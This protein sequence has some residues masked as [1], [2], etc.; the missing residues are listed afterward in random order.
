MME[1]ELIADYQCVTG[2]GPL[3]QP[4]EQCVYWVD[5]PL[6]RMFRYDPATGKHEQFYE[7]GVIGGYTLQAD[8]SFLLF[9][10]KGAIKIL[11]NGKLM[12]VLDGIPGEEASRFNDVIADPRGG[13][14]CGTMPSPDSL[15]HLYYLSPEGQITKL[16]DGIAISNGFGF[17]PD[18]KQ[19]YYTLSHPKRI[20]LFDYNQTTGA[21]ANQRVFVDTTGE[22]GV[23]DGMAVD[24][25]GDVWS[26]RWD[27]WR[28]TRYNAMGKELQR[29]QFPVK[30][31]SSVTFGGP[32]YTD[33]YITS[34][35]GNDKV[36]NGPGAGALFR[37]RLGIKGQPPYRSHVGLAK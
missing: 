16:I 34:A 11:R 21:L 1:P 35:G 14:F 25:Q 33:M 15:G 5:I 19:L 24:A 17:T 3:W 27:G 7:G 28:L 13:V 10:D 31:V 18:R 36:E 2:E 22:D 9:M 23:P 26:A 8:G 29:V 37:L 4:D 32:D 6:G 20:L 12:T 30:K